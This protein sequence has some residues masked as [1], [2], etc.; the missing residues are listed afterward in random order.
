MSTVLQKTSAGTA[1][2]R[3]RPTAAVS[4]TATTGRVSGHGSTSMWDP[5]HWPGPVQRLLLVGGVLGSAVGLFLGLALG[6]HSAQ[7]VLLPYLAGFLLGMALGATAGLVLVGLRAGRRGS[8]C[9]QHG[10]PQIGG[11]PGR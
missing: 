11:E 4:T 2:H 6:D 8:H 10:R 1:A 9:A 7:G 3:A 5:D